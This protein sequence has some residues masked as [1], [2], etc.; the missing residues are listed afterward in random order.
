MTHR[1]VVPSEGLKSEHY[2]LKAG[3]FDPELGKIILDLILNTEEF[4]VYVAADYSIQWHTT[5]DHEASEH[6]GEVLNRV[7]MMEAQSHFIE[8][9]TTL[10]SV[11]RQIAEGLARCLDAHSR[12]DCMLVL[13]EAELQLKARNKE[14]AWKWYFTSAY[15][16]SGACI[17]I[18]GAL[19]VFRAYVATA[20]GTNAFEVS[21]GV[22]MGAIGALLSAT[23]RADRLVMNAM[24]GKTILRLEGLSRIGAGLIG[25]LFVALTVKSGIIMGGIHFAGSQLAVLLAMCLAA[26]AS[27][28]L[29]P[30]LIETFEKIAKPADDD[31]A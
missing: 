28:R 4:I 22:L 2:Q 16:V 11:R 8:D 17:V 20:L 1:E 10:L 29:V 14:T 6:H 18:F 31:S 26:G 30:S 7:G 3:D 19:W 9:K 21:L 12:H 15:A 24:A 23:T 13:D 25:A 5:D 27:E